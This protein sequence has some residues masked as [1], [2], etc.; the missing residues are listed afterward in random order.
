MRVSAKKGLLIALAVLLLGTAALFLVGTT[1]E[2]VT[3]TWLT[4]CSLGISIDRYWRLMRILLWQIRE[5]CHIRDKR[6][7]D[8]AICLCT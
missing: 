4:L 2:M 6:I 7:D 5:V 3:V 8:L 1:E